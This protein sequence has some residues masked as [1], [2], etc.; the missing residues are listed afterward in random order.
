MES[1][2]LEVDLDNPN[3]TWSILRCITGKKMLKHI[4]GAGTVRKVPIKMSSVTMCEVV[5]HFI[6]L[7]PE[8]NPLTQRTTGDEQRTP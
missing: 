1:N 5:L 3:K 2:L 8:S 4:M 6:F 7:H